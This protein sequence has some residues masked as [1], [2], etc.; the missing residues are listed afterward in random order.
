M[1]VGNYQHLRLEEGLSCPFLGKLH[2][3]FIYS[4]GF[5]FF[6]FLQLQDIPLLLGVYL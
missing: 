5:V 3:Y 2:L 1:G 6:S 4:L